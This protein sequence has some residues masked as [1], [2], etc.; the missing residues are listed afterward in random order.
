MPGKENRT[1]PSQLPE[2]SLEWIRNTELLE[3]PGGARRLLEHYGKIP[4]NDVMQHINQVRYRALETYPYP[5]IG[6]YRFLDIQIVKSRAY[7][8]IVARLNKGEQ[9]LDVGCCIGQEL[10]QLV[11]DGAKS[12][13]LYGVDLYDKFF[14][15][16]YDLFRDRDT[17]K[18]TLIAA[19][20]FTPKPMLSRL[21]GKFDVIWTSNVLHLFTW[22]KQVTA[23]AA[24]LKLLSKSSNSMIAG[25]FMGHSTPG[26]YNYGFRGQEESIYRH[27]DQSFK[28]MFQTACDGLEEAWEADVEAPEWKETLELR[29]QGELD[30]TWTLELKFVARRLGK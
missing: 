6:H 7:N 13:N 10:R 21:E 2:L 23:V 17:F 20:L 16:S 22:E 19:D 29:S 18:G 30:S 8:E 15:I 9:L 26:G 27:D 5:C 28:K 24:M 3:V 25:R 14:D 1:D 12:E 4:H 11:A